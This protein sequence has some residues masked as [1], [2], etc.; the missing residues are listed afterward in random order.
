MHDC[1]RYR[2]DW[3]AGKEEGQVDCGDC[4]SFCEDA[5]AILIATVVGAPPLPD[6]TDEYWNGFE[7]RLRKSLVRENAA[8]SL[9]AYWK[10]APVAAGAAIAAVVTWGSIRP[11][12]PAPPAPPQI[13]TQQ[14]AAPQI[15][16]VDDH[17]QGLDPMVVAYLERSE[18]FLR[19]YTKI[20]PSDKEDLDDSRALAKQSLM[21]IGEQKKLA[22]NFAPVRITL[23]QYEN[24]LR[25]I[26]NLNSTQE[27]TDVQTRILSH[28]L[29]ANMK[30]YQPQVILVSGRY[31]R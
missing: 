19:T 20:E 22:G 11:A 30:A 14:T 8:R 18:L 15:E 23:D 2:E 29:I 4:R 10:W 26:K 1:Q 17:I 13:T 25:E 21:E 5:N 27:L 3:L 9:R 16:V 31:G 24:V 28:G 7:N 12:P 6:V